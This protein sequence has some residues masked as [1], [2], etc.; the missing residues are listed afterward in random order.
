MEG[1]QVK[2]RKAEAIAIVA[3]PPAHREFAVKINRRG[4]AICRERKQIF[5][6]AASIFD[7]REVRGNIRHHAA[8]RLRR[9][10]VIFEAWRCAI[11]IGERH[12]CPKK[13]AGAC[14]AIGR[15][16]Q[17]RKESQR[18]L[19]TIQRKKSAVASS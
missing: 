12:I 19:L 7:R 15:R 5:R 8:R 10:G 4:S 6:V 3:A 16:T 9:A 14:A 18:C 13:P 1:E 11:V 17:K 2:R